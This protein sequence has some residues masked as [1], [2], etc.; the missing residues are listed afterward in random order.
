MRSLKA[1]SEPACLRLD[2][3]GL[4]AVGAGA[5]E[6]KGARGVGEHQHDL[7]VDLAGVHGVQDG[8]QVGA[9]AGAEHGD[10]LA[11]ASTSLSPP[12]AWGATAPM[13]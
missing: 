13:R 3:Q 5:L 2:E 7:A 11:H 9:A 8:L 4:D 1:A 12:S 10:A 6:R